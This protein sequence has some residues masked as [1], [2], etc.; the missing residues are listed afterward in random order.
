MKLYAKIKKSSEY[1]HQN[2]RPD[3]T[4]YGLPFEV[5][6]DPDRVHGDKATWDDYCVQGGPGGQYTLADVE[7]Y[8]KRSDGVPVRIR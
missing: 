8:I 1:H 2:P 5:T 7:L 3:D 4:V 6:I